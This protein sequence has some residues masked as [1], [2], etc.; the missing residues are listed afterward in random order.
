MIK[1]DYKMHLNSA[2]PLP[3]GEGQGEGINNETFGEEAALTGYRCCLCV[4]TAI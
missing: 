2:S 1:K 4:F 3:P